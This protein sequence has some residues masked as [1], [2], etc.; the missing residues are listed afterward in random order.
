MLFAPR[1]PAT[2]DDEVEADERFDR[3]GDGVALAV[4]GVGELL[5]DG[6]CFSTADDELEVSSLV[7]YACI[8]AFFSL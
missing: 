7:L 2:V 6:P 3:E 8:Q 4:F 1:F 5:Y